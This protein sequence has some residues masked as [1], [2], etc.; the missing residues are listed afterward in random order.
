[1][2]TTSNQIELRHLRYF[3]AVAEE[4]NFHRAADKLFISQPGLSRQIKQ[5]EFYLGFPLFIRD[6]KSVGLTEPGVFFRKE[7]DVILNQIERTIEHTSYIAGGQGG[8]LKIGFVGSAMQNVLPDLIIASTRKHPQLTFSFE[9]MR[10]AM[11]I[12]ML[13]QSSLDLGFVRLDS[14][15]QELILRPV[16]ED[17]F[18]LVLPI[19][20]PLTAENFCDM[21]QLKSASF[22]LFQ[23]KYSPVYYKEVLSICEDAGFKPRISHNSVHASTI[24]RLVENG[25][26]VSIVPTSLQKGYQMNVKFIELKDIHQKAR[27]SIVYNKNNRNPSLKLILEIIDTV[28]MK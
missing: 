22:I 15:P 20:H 28:L 16:F 9:E 14:V 5:L 13:L 18:S 7:V 11:Q 23:P 21:S 10:N 12:E 26:G 25:L 1:M 17:T 2:I 6:K 27:L 24:Y 8:A 3:Q 4:L 19:D